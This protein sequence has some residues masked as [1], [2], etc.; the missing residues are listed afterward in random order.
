MVQS[1]RIPGLD[2]EFNIQPEIEYPVR[3]PAGYRNIRP[4]ILDRIPNNSLD[5]VLNLTSGRISE[6]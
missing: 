4:A 3:Y 1:Y 2:T 5:R 6:I